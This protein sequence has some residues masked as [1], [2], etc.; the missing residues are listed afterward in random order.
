MVGIGPSA[1]KIESWDVGMRFA[2]DSRPGFE[3]RSRGFHRELD[4]RHGQGLVG[5]RVPRDVTRF[6]LDLGHLRCGARF[7]DIS[8]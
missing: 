1:P 2:S 4:T 6:L 7:W 3:P 5:C 8:C